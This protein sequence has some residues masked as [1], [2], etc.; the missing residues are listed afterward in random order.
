MKGKMKT[1]RLW[2]MVIAGLCMIAVGVHVSYGAIITCAF[3]ANSGTSC[4]GTP[5]GMTGCTGLPAGGCSPSTTCYTC[6][7][8]IPVAKRLC[9]T[10]RH[11]PGSIA[12]ILTGDPV[13][14]GTLSEENCWWS[15][16]VCACYSD[17]P[18]E[19]GDCYYDECSGNTTH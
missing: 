11:I 2:P 13:K 3:C 19:L 18:S 17:T 6:D 14:C 8:S 10:V 9:Q 4:D 7:G 15:G 5:G 12:C 16:V 1:L